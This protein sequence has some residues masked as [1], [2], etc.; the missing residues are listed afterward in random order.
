MELVEGDSAAAALAGGPLDPARVAR[1]VEVVADA[2]DAAH[3]LHAPPEQ[4]MVHRDV[5]PGNILLEP[6]SRGREHAYLVDFGVARTVAAGPRITGAGAV[7]GTPAYMAPELW[8]GRAADHR[9]DVYALAVTAFELLTGVL[10][11]ARGTVEGLVAA[12]LTAPPPA[13]SALRPALPAA[14][15]AALARGLAKDPAARPA[16]A[17]EF[18]ADLGA[19]LHPARPASGG[20]AP[21]TVPA[22]PGPA[23]AG[24]AAVRPVPTTVVPPAPVPPAPVPPPGPTGPPRPDGPV[25]ASPARRAWLASPPHFA[26]LAAT[27]AVVPLLLADLLPA[28]AALLLAASLLYALGAVLAVLLR[29]R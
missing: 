3:A 2:L 27:A 11:F 24:R 18:A 17:G 4:R 15:D 7:V 25:P 5:K 10:P 26:G 9:V 16:T 21:R 1:L 14:V 20:A 19:A 29:R 23:R 13:A 8:E 22:S 28:D 12:H 6:R